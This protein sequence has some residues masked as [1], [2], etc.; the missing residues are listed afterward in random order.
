MQTK[1]DCKVAE[2]LYPITGSTLN[3]YCKSNFL[4]EMVA[5]LF[6]IRADSVML[7]HCVCMGSLP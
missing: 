1:V 2:K 5:E 4:L 7:N 6:S 3:S